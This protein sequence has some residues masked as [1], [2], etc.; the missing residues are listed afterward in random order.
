MTATITLAFL[1][2]VAFVLVFA[3]LMV[4]LVVLRN[5][6]TVASARTVL[7]MDT[8]YGIG[9]TVVVV[10]GL[11][12][13]FYTEKGAAYYFASGPFL[14]KL[15]LFIVVGLLSIYPTLKF[16]I[17]RAA[18]REQRVP[19]FD[20]STRRRVRMLIHVELTLLVVILLLAPMMARG[21]GFLG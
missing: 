19:A 13:V 7:R 9:A 20:P 11:L 8:V 3:A 4:E 15:A 14:A 21:V 1:H 6:L 17:W 2:H 16:L 18:L 12:R 10:V 5:D